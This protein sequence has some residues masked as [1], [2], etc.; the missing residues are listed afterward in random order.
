M[1]LLIADH[2]EHAQR[3]PFVGARVF[4][5][6]ARRG[7]VGGLLAELGG[8]ADTLTIDRTLTPFWQV[9]LLP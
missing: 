6:S 3:Q 1:L 7:Q 9:T 2:G 4:G 8:G 5:R